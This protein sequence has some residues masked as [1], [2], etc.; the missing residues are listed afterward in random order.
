MSRR[1][2]SRMCAMGVCVVHGW[3]LVLRLLDVLERARISVGT[4]VGDQ[5]GHMAH[6]SGHDLA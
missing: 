3:S 1:M 5:S 6:R 2:G 4:T